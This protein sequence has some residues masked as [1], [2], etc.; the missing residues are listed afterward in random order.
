MHQKSVTNGRT[1]ARTP[2]KQYAPSFSSKL[3]AKI[4]V[5]AVVAIVVVAAVEVVVLV[6]VL[7][8]LLL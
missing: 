7:S 6:D 3:G 8:L 5:E 1:S 2:Q 4:K